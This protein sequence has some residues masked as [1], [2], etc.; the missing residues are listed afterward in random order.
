MTRHFVIKLWHKSYNQY[1]RKIEYAKPR[2]YLW[3]ATK[4]FNAIRPDIFGGYGW[5]CCPETADFATAWQELKTQQ[6]AES[7]S[8]L[9]R[10]ISLTEVVDAS[11]EVKC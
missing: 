5:L 4:E 8:Q 3:D 10:V 11:Y 2:C 6:L 1:G 9:N 7:W